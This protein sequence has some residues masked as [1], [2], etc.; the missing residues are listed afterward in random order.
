[1]E[2]P[3]SGTLLIPLALS[4]ICYHHDVSSRGI[5]PVKGRC[6]QKC[7]IYFSLANTCER[8]GLTL[9]KAA[10][11]RMGRKADVAGL[12]STKIHPKPLVP[13]ESV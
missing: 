11:S 6:P 9:A 13:S 2:A 5:A 12:A 4:P 7:A 3:P 1:M 8:D 10:S